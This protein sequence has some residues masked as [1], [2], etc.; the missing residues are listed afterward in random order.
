MLLALGGA[1]DSALADSK[2]FQKAVAYQGTPK[3]AKNCTGC[4]LFQPPNACKNVD[5]VIEPTGSAES[6][7]QKPDIIIG[8][9][10]TTRRLRSARLR[11]DLGTSRSVIKAAKGSCTAYAAVSVPTAD[12]ALTK[13]KPRSATATASEARLLKTIAFAAL[14]S[15][16]CVAGRSVG[17]HPTRV[18]QPINVSI[19]RGAGM[20][21][22]MNK[23]LTE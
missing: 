15:N 11:R 22:A 9:L 17:C 5:G 7:E 10:T 23:G 4:S 6:G 20:C 21:R 3:G 13:A 1:A 8:C 18:P 19:Q 16:E 2:V 14:P 12:S